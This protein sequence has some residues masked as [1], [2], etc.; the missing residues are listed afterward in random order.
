MS[1]PLDWA[2]LLGGDRR[3]VRWIIPGLFAE[4]RAYAVISPAK[5]G[6]SL[7]MLE[8][9]A[10]AQVPALYIDYENTHTD[11]RDR[12]NAMDLKAA[13]LVNLHYV[14]FPDFRPLNTRA[15]AVQLLDLVL[16]L[17]PRVVVIDT[18]SRAVDGDEND[19]KMWNDLY[20]LVA[21]PLKR[22]GVTLIR[23]DHSGHA[24]RQRARG[25]SNKDTD[26]DGTWILS[27][28]SSTLKLE[29]GV[30]RS[31]D[32][33]PILK[34]DKRTDPLAF[35]PVAT[36]DE[37]AGAKVSELIDQL[38]CLDISPTV[39]RPTVERHLRDAGI[40]FSTDALGQAIKRRRDRSRTEHQTADRGQIEPAAAH[41]PQDESG[42]T[43]VSR[44]KYQVGA[45]PSPPGQRPVS[46]VS[47]C[48]ELTGPAPLLKKRGP[49]QSQ[50]PPSSSPSSGGKR[51]PARGTSGGVLAAAERGTSGELDATTPP[52]GYPPT[53]EDDAQSPSTLQPWR[54]DNIRFGSTRR[55][56][57]DD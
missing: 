32:H 44:Q 3:P 22:L 42:Q 6:K 57:I 41:K 10:R 29:V 16:R 1:K 35:V 39:G 50:H 51:F 47:S 43:L 30:Q 31:G 25:S 26:V 18:I 17:E 34:Y 7:F 52:D 49:G 40:R 37:R 45:D 56:Y 9:L 8:Q 21:L 27:A 15:G 36:P 20:R 23:L 48:E 46:E 19:P 4:G 5:S 13:D 2:Q 14:S 38:D 33:P 12:I 55:C 24:N 53:V 54:D 11:L 28:T